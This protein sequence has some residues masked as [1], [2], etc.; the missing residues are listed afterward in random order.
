MN[1]FLPKFLGGVILISGIG[2][3]KVELKSMIKILS[4][5]E[6]AESLFSRGTWLSV[7]GKAKSTSLQTDGHRSTDHL[8][9]SFL[10]RKCM[11]D[12]WLCFVGHEGGR[13]VTQM[14]VQLVSVNLSKHPDPVL[15][16]NLKEG[17]ASFL[18]LY[19][20]NHFSKNKTTMQALYDAF[21]MLL[22]SVSAF[23]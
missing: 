15:A 10:L 17:I 5:A 1:A 7:L 3:L 6:N 23:Q 19:A 14:E 9:R 22:S 20:M 12:F 2:C 21:L 4:H 16:D 18:I 8:N 11:R 13:A